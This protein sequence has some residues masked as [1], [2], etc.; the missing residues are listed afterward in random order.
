MSRRRTAVEYHHRTKHHFQR[1][2]A[3]AGF[4]DWTTQPHPFRRFAGVPTVALPLGPE[5][6][7]PGYDALFTEASPASPLDADSLGR[8]LYLSLALS[9]GKEVVDPEGNVVS[10]WS[11]RVNPS[12]GNLHPTEGYVLI[13]AAAGLETG[14]G[15]YH[16]APDEHLLELRATG[17]VPDPGT[18]FL[19]GLTSIAWREAWKYGE[20][21]FRYCQHDVGHA[22]A[23][24]SLAGRCL[25]WRLRLLTDLEVGLADRVLAV[26]GLGG[27]E[28]ERADVLVLVDTGTG[29]CPQVGE[30]RGWADSRMVLGEPNTLSPGHR[31]WD[32]IDTVADAC[33]G[34]VLPGVGAPAD[35][36]APATLAAPSFAPRDD[37][38]A[39]IIRNRRSARGMDRRSRLGQEDFARLLA[40]LLPAGSADVLPALP[41][42]PEVSL[43]LFVHR[44][45]GLA[46]GLYALPRHPE[47]ETAW[48]AAMRPDFTWDPV[49]GMPAELPLR[50]LIAGDVRETAKRLSCHQ[51]IA[52]DGAFSVGMV[53]RFSAGIAEHGA[54]WYPRLF[55][56]TGMIGQLLYLEAEAA[57]LRGTGIGCFFDDEVHRLLGL[58]DD[59]W[60]SLYHFTVGGPVKDPRLR[61]TP[62][63]GAFSR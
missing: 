44:V 14:A 61:T 52:A 4:M 7:G 11:L 34:E 13:G 2:A 15:L 51:D 62:P 31:I 33:H 25:G 46:P 22:L 40:R 41:Q 24:L 45:E 30:L 56:E 18:G 29:A 3:S 9:A 47:H 1:Y 20:R 42:G 5:T 37:S 54:A 27:P 12:S 36:A 21:A 28:R 59:A 23:A 57:G 50:H 26:D 8:F 19:L 49:P 35:L 39:A 6:G 17:P 60:Q 10:R 63:Y 16:Y 55:W 32:A 38:A 43:L 48:R 58:R 53:A